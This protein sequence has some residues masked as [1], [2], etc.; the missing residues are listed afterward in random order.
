MAVKKL[1]DKIQEYFEIEMYFDF[2]G[3]SKK[4]N[5]FFFGP[6]YPLMDPN[7]YRCRVFPKIFAKNL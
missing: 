6:N 3:H 7:Y 1:V 4:K 5:I 2:H